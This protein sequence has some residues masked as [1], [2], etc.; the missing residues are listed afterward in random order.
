M[1]K[2]LVSMI[3]AIFMIAALSIPLVSA[4]TDADLDT[5]QKVSVTLNCNKEGYA[6]EIFRIAD[7]ITGTNPYTVKCDVKVNDA[8]VKAAVANGNYEAADSSKILDALDNDT[9]LAGAVSVGTYT[10]DEDGNTKT[11]SDLSQ[12]IYYV[13]AVDFPAG[14]KS[15]ANSCFA[16]PYCTESGWVYSLDTINLATK[17]DDDEPEIFKE[18]TNSTKGDV[19]Y[20]DVS[21]GD[22]VDF[23]ITSSVM[24]V[25]SDVPEH[26]FRLNSYVIS[27]LMSKGLTLD[28]NSFVVTLADDD[29]DTIGTI[30][31]ENYT[32]DVTAA[33]GEDTTF[34]VS[35]KKECLQNAD[36]YD[37]AYVVT[38]F[39]AV[40]NKYA[41]TEVT[42]NPNE[43]VKLTYTNKNDVQ[44]EV[45]G[46]KVYV[47]TYQLEV[48][49]L[50]DAGT[51]LQGAEFALYATEADAKDEKNAIATGVS[52]AEGVV[53][54][55]NADN[56]V[57]RVDSGKYF[58][59]ETKAPD[60]YNKYTDVIPVQINVT[61]TRTFTN[62]TFIQNAPEHGK[63][64]V[65]VKNTKTVLPQTGGQGNLI[66][67]SIAISFALVGGIIF[68]VAKKKKKNSTEKAA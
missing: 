29:Y 14:V 5:N 52:D 65:E 28:Q 57:M 49:K 34:T 7:L 18:I 10:V 37:A 38:N 23:E 64:V 6:F 47:Y 15:V 59:K 20:T 12:G 8:T 21:I 40:L 61:Y 1:T 2:R 56:E 68:F 66:I 24:G 11:F 62:G 51:K 54:F 26:D 55:K 67:Y 45:E 41:T 48:H 17:I 19:R 31:P 30:D 50:D 58:V 22:T 25:V 36:F 43:A 44:G 63:A 4:A 3:I 27:D 32:V 35:L 13:R 16:L 53:E 60:G 46:N 33:E 9:E 42:G 39:S